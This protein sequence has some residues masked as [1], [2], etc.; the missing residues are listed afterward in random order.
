LFHELQMHQLELEMQNRELREAQSAMKESR[1]RYA[2][3]YDFAPVAYCTL[4]Q[5]GTIVELNLTAARMFGVPRERAQGRPLLSLAKLDQPDL[6]VQHLNPVRRQAGADGHRADAVPAGTQGRGRGRQCPVLGLD[7]H[8]FP[9]SHCP[10]RHH[11]AAKWAELERAQ[12]H[13]SEQRLRQRLQ[14]LEAAH[15][16]VSSVLALKPEGAFEQVSEVIT[17]HARRVLATP[18]WPRSSSRIARR[19][20]ARARPSAPPSSTAFDSA[21]GHELR[22]ELAYTGCLPGHAARAARGAGAAL[23]RARPRDPDDVRRAR[24]QWPADS[25]S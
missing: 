8:A 12:A 10:D 16:E 21:V 22:A 14:A 7:Q 15:V 24:L 2:N 20:R 13:A 19:R 9:V 25:P 18:I 11:R 6:L 17:R 1:N 5:D 23:L 3:L 4:S